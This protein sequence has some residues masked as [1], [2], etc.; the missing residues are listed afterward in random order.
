MD[1]CQAQM[2]KNQANISLVRAKLIWDDFE[3]EQHNYSSFVKNITICLSGDNFWSNHLSYKSVAE[4]WVRC[5]LF[6]CH[7]TGISYL[8]IH[9]NNSVK[10]RGKRSMSHFPFWHSPSRVTFC[11]FVQWTVCIRD[12]P[13]IV[14]LSTLA[15][16]LAW[17]K[18]KNYVKW[19]WWEIQAG[20]ADQLVHNAVWMLDLH[21]M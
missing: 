10:Q 2:Y 14:I 4:T 19:Q 20:V 11:L 5:S 21:N 16:L 13:S 3:G 9:T 8:P 17:A 7:K 18:K 15:L 1:C 12:Y 6:L